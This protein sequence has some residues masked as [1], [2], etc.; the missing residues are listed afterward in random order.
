MIKRIALFLLAALTLHAQ[1]VGPRVEESQPFRQLMMQL[2]GAVSR[3]MA[4]YQRQS[5]IEYGAKH[6]GLNLLSVCLSVFFV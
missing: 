3:D 1:A 4:N 6:A 5:D 2:T